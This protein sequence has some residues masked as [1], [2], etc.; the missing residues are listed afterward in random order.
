MQAWHR[1]WAEQA[2]RVLRPGGHLL[3]FGGTR[4]YHRLACAVEDAGFEIRDSIMWLYGSGFPK[5]HDVSKAIDKAAGAGRKVVRVGKGAA[6]QRTESLGAY[7]P[8]YTATVPSTPE[9]ARWEG[10]GTALKPAHEPI[11]VARKPLIGT[12]AKN[13]LRHG[14]GGI[15]VA[16]CRI[17]HANAA[18]LSASLAKNPGRDDEVSSVVYGADRPQQSVNRNGRWPANVVLSHA[19]DCELVGVRKVK[20]SGSVS[21]NEAS[22]KTDVVLGNFAGRTP[23][24]AYADEDG[25]ETVEAWE[26]APR[27]PVAMLD[28]QSG[29]LASAGNVRPSTRQTG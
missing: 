13:V 10:W 8:E 11:V 22:A 21:R 29:H 20:G 4:T 26:C 23:F 5:S 24:V 6:T 19:E 15:N 14:T 25:A 12:V 27:C 7:E 16:G 18:D 28:L 17:G 2:L 3:A 1:R 9:A